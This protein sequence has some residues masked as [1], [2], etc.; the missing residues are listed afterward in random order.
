MEC[1]SHGW[2]GL[3]LLSSSSLASL[4]CQ[5][6]SC[7]R[8][9]CFSCELDAW[10]LHNQCLCGSWGSLRPW[11]WPLCLCCLLC[12]WRSIFSFW[13]PWRIRCLLT[14]A[15]WG[16]SPWVSDI[17]ANRP[18]CPFPQSTALH[19]F[20][21]GA[22]SWLSAVLKAWDSYAWMIYGSDCQGL[23]KPIQFQNSS[24]HFL[25]FMAQ[26]MNSRYQLTCFVI[27]KTLIE[28]VFLKRKKIQGS[29]TSFFFYP[30]T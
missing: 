5:C 10:S 6:W 3:V 18:S 22:L 30:V 27:V 24:S 28:A 20:P 11:H 25:S 4:L 26:L 9:E 29:F 23:L 17:P 13:W 14:S 1:E 15:P 21:A 12:R 7:E 19:L 2:C 8:K 16:P